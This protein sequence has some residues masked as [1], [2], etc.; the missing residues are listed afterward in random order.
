[1]SQPEPRSR[2]RGAALESAIL[3]ATLDELAER[4]YTQLTMEGVAA[5]AGASKASLYRRWPTR[6]E[7]VMAAVRHTLPGKV[8]VPDHGTLR[9]DLVAAFTVII[10]ELTGPIGAALRG[11][12][13]EAIGSDSVAGLSA[14]SGAA[15]LGAI[16][17]RAV[18]RGEVAPDRDPRWAIEAGLATLRYR[19]LARG[20][21]DRTVVVGIVDEVMVPL[22]TGQAP[23]TARNASVR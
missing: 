9:D 17:D 18:V 20:A 21:V 6:A 11:V 16:V 13:A 15:T 5:R 10:G 19:F 3:D 8:A 2:R 4:G 7:L 1:M 22:L 23:A 12:I 14:G